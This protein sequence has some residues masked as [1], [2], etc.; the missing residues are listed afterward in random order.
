MIRPQLY[1]IQGVFTIMIADDPL[2]REIYSEI[3]L[4]PT[5]C[6]PYYRPLERRRLLLLQMRLVYGL[7]TRCGADEHGNPGEIDCCLIEVEVEVKKEGK[8]EGG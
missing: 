7:I 5:Q 8:D 1:S 6:N 3:L 2:P 4:D